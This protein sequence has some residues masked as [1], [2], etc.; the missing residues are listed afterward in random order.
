MSQDCEAIVAVYATHAQAEDAVKR[1]A[2]ANFDIQ[3][4]SIV[5]K[6]YELEERVVGFY[7]AGQRIKMWG[8]NGAFWGGL[9]GLFVGGIFMTIPVVGHLVVLGHLATML[10]AA[11]GGAAI[12]GGLSALGAALVT[13]GIPKQSVLEYEAAVRANKFLVVAH[14][15]PEEGKR[16]RALLHDAEP[17]RLDTHP[18]P[19]PAPTSHVHA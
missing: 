1:L 18:I 4:L 19:T 15:T 5:G 7:S 10:A 2:D 11:A 3:K 14:G 13:L 12:V 8:K 16:A 17:E 9:W 6:G